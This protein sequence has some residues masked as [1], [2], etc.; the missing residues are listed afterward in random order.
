MRTEL[1]VVIQQKLKYIC[2]KMIYRM[3]QYMPLKK[4]LL[5]RKMVSDIMGHHVWAS[6]QGGLRPGK[7]QTGLRSY[8]D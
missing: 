4:E 7:T 6:S 5:R 1:Y 3:F 8:R 2:F